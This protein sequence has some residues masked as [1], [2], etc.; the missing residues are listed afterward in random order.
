MSQHNESTFGLLPVLPNERV[1]NGFDFSMVNIGLAIAT[2][3]FLIGGTLSEFVDLKMGIAASI[4]G[5]TLGI[6]MM[7]LA[8]S[9]PSSKYGIDQ[10]VSL[11]SVL[12]FH[13]VKLALAVMVLIEFGW[14]AVLAI[15]F[16][17]A[18]TNILSEI[19]ALSQS[20]LVSIVVFAFLAIVISWLIVAKGPV[21]IKWLNRIVAPGLIIILIA[22]LAILLSRYSWGELLALQPINPAPDRWWNYMVVFELNLAA[23]LS[24]WPIMGGLTRLCQSQRV[25]F[26][27]NLLG[28]NLFAVF[29]QIVGLMSGLALG[30]SDPTE[31]MIPLAGPVLGMIV[32]L[33]VAFA[34]VTSIT[35]LAYSTSMALKQIK[36][37]ER[38]DWSRLTFYFFALTVPFIFFPDEV[39][40]H[41]ST[42]LAF[43][44]T[45]FGPLSA[46]YFVDFFVLRRQRLDIGSL[47]LEGDGKPYYYWG[48]FNWAG[49]LAVAI[50]TIIYFIILDPLTFDSSTAFLYMTASIPA[51]LLAGV[52]HYVLSKMITVPKGLGAYGKQ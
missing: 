6:I 44:G 51:I 17:R 9:I 47:Y 33:F 30:T 50:A 38:M 42:F 3:G 24:W 26:W 29:G 18:S 36:F 1:W 5:N 34:N 13:G 35:S 25:A 21:S 22:M 12:G 41:F 52:L 15:M 27:P 2:W 23:G 20:S 7:A 46:V 16:G 11:R 37:I 31:W 48:G 45:I 19:T 8:T 49:I 32:L 4:A 43:S 40:S 14:C 10:Y 39:Y 28:L